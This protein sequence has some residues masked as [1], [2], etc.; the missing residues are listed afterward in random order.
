MHINS[1]LERN[2]WCLLASTPISTP[3]S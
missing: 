1:I 2:R 3:G